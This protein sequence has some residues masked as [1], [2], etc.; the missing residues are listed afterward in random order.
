[1][2]TSVKC[3]EHAHLLAWLQVRQDDT[4]GLKGFSYFL[5]KLQGV[6]TLMSDMT[7][8][9]HVRNMQAIVPK[10]PT[11]AWNKWPSAAT[12]NS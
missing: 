6:M 3:R 12:R 1:M 5:I 11:Y 2:K 4:N 8:L 7:V 9:N 10:R